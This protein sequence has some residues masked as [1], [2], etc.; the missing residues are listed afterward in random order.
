MLNGKQVL[1]V[2]NFPPKQIG[3]F[4]SECLITGVQAEA[5]AVTLVTLDCPV[6]N[7]KKLY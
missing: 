1:A 5:G 6:E 3:P 4:V 7:G 2:I